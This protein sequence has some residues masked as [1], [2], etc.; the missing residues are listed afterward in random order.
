MVKLRFRKNIFEYHG[1][2]LYS[3]YFQAAFIYRLVALSLLV[4]PGAGGAEA[5]CLNSVVRGHHIYEDICSSVHGE[6]LYCKRKISNVYDL[7]TVSAVI[8]H[9][10]GIVGHLPKRISTPCHL[11]LRSIS[12]IVNERRQYLRY[13]HIAILKLPKYF[14]IMFSKMACDFRNI[15]K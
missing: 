9:G 4:V 1:I 15:R 7:Y 5:F 8:K 14:E 3:K 13:F 12:C 6:E 10:M 2:R 11:I